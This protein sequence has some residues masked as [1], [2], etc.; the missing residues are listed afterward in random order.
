MEGM[1]G[2][3]KPYLGRENS[4][5]ADLKLIISIITVSVNGLSIQIKEQILRLCLKSKT[6]LCTAYKKLI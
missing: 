6:Q 1:H 5:M 2:Q 4:K 3:H